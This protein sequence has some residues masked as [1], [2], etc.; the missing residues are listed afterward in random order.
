[1]ANRILDIGHTEDS[2]P[3]R[4]PP[5]SLTRTQFNNPVLPGSQWVAGSW[6]LKVAK[7]KNCIGLHSA[8][9]GVGGWERDANERVRYV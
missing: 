6:A 9:S 8:P 3:C 2:G 7:L 4:V 5:V 1:M